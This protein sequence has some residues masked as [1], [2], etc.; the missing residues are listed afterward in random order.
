MSKVIM[1]SRTFPATHP[2]KGEPTHFVEKIWKSFSV[3]ALGETFYLCMDD[4]CREL[5]KNAPYSLVSDFLL[6]LNKYSNADNEVHPKHHTIRAGKRWKD[7]D[8]ASLR[9]W[10]GKPYR[11]KQIII[12][13][14]VK[15]TVK[16]IE[17]NKL[18]QVWIDGEL[19]GDFRWPKQFD[20][21]ISLC[22]NDGVSSQDL[23]DW[24]KNRLPLG[25]QILCWNTDNLPY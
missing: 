8:T 19:V 25:G 6:S 2:R 11:S 9:I 17:I 21:L 10:S 15:I 5:N 22:E 4:D 3:K 23:T 12:A 7:G 14:D 20:K 1:V 24:F 18:W 13:S 16:D